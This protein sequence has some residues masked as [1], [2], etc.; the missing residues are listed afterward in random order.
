MTRAG[1]ALL[2]AVDICIGSGMAQA[3]TT[4]IISQGTFLSGASMG[5]GAS[6]GLIASIGQPA[7][8]VSATQ[9]TDSLKLGFAHTIQGDPDPG[10]SVCAINI[11][12]NPVRPQCINNFTPDVV[13]L[14]PT[15]GSEPFDEVSFTTTVLDSRGIPVRGILVNPTETSHSVNIV[16]GGSTAAVTDVYGRATVSVNRA[17]GYGHLGP[18]ADG[19]VLCEVEVRSPDVAFNGINCVLPTSGTS[20]V[21]ASDESNITCGF[22][23]HWGVV[24]PGVNNWWDLTCDNVVNAT[25]E[26]GVLGKGGYSDHVSHSGVLG[27]KETCIP[28]A[29]IVGVTVIASKTSFLGGASE[30]QETSASTATT[31]DV[32]SAS[33]AIVL[34]AGKSLLAFPS[35]VHGRVL[36][37]LYRLDTPGAYE[38][39]VF[40]ISGRRVQTLSAGQ[41]Q[42]GTH[43]TLWTT[44]DDRGR[45]VST[46]V[47][48]VRLS[49]PQPLATWRVTVIR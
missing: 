29:S 25:D 48:F 37:I 20:Y 43:Q 7:T 3:Q 32:Q 31:S 14:C 30:A 1:L 18:C 6:Y 23:A 34:P 5:T 16:T 12:Q 28:S 4:Y 27:F 2:L 8:G 22:L 24:T 21:N 36:Q 44:K 39:S 38:L 47:Y 11:A 45:P 10:L 13:R 46:G 40:D 41:G 9:A 33:K 15:I 26:Q 17:S 42:P 35:P 49:G 19:V